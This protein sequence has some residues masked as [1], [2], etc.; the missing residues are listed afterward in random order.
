MEIF[1][2]AAGVSAKSRGGGV[3]HK[4]NAHGEFRAK[5][6]ISEPGLG[7]RA[8]RRHRDPEGGRGGGGTLGQCRAPAGETTDG[9]KGFYG[10]GATGRVF[11]LGTPKV[12][13][14]RGRAFSEFLARG[15]AGH[16]DTAG[17]WGSRV[18]LAKRGAI[19][20]EKDG[21]FT[22]KMAAGG[23]IRR[24]PTLGSGRIFPTVT[25]GFDGSRWWGDVVS[26]T[27]EKD[28]GFGYGTT[29]ELGC[30]PYLSAT[31]GS[32]GIPVFTGKSA[33]GASGL[34]VARKS[35]RGTKKRPGGS[36]RRHQPGGTAGTWTF[37]WDNG[38]YLNGVGTGDEA[39]RDAAHPEAEN[40]R[41]SG[42]RPT[43]VRTSGG[44]TG[45][46]QPPNPK[47]KKKRVVGGKQDRRVTDVLARAGAPGGDT[48]ESQG[49]LHA[50]AAKLPFRGTR[51]PGVFLR[52]NWEKRRC[53]WRARF[54]AGPGGAGWRES[55]TEC[56]AATSIGKVPSKAHFLVRGAFGDVGKVGCGMFPSGARKK[57]QAGG[58]WLDDKPLAK[59]ARCLSRTAFTEKRKATGRKSRWAGK[60][61]GESG[62]MKRTADKRLTADPS[63]GTSK[64]PARPPTATPGHISR[65]SRPGTG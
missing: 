59:A 48:K 19:R 49:G 53:D 8:K 47:E 33:T 23:G 43:C 18:S 27:F 5:T 37:W 30:G 28:W 62:V 14:T 35:W 63:G 1:G 9:P 41:R 32:R 50:T 13:H 52:S 24:N 54:F 16:G 36:V 12:S 15:S 51:Q 31:P 10:R 21:G 26:R 58:I 11:G 40:V 25:S 56:K 22:E 34:G 7:T 17:G 4:T 46:M 57:P 55:G 61:G 45:E 64:H 44:T 6:D 65:E 2:R 42:S 60:G 39:K 38:H 29:P 20:S 3:V